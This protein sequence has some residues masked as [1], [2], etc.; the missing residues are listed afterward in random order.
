[1]LTPTARTSYI[2]IEGSVVAIGKPGLAAVEVW[3]NGPLALEAPALTRAGDLRVGRQ[4]CAARRLFELH[5]GALVHPE[6]GKGRAA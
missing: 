4:R 3:I 5:S 2:D 6:S 1:M